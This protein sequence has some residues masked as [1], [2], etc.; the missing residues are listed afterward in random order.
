MLILDLLESIL[1]LGLPMAGLSWFL[2]FQLY[3][4]GHVDR[5]ADRKAIKSQVKALR[6]GFKA[7]A[8]TKVRDEV[9]SRKKADIVYDKW[10]WFGSGFYGL[11]ALWTFVII[12]ITEIFNFIFGFPGW[13]V[14]FSDG[15]IS[16]VVDLLINQI[17]NLVTAFVW[18]SF[19]D[20]DS[21]WLW[22]LMAWLGYWVGVEA[23]RR[24]SEIPVA[25]WIEKLRV[26]FNTL[27]D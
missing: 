23:A 8:K 14:L 4:S 19:W 9:S 20:A 11:A 21:I 7:R 6:A 1:K 25:G 27:K 26:F 5:G 12:E 10:M 17:Q 18:F 15:V 3:H 16:L 2:F 13:A 24:E 22:V